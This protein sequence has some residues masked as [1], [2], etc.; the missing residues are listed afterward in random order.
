MIAAAMAMMGAPSVIAASS[1][2]G[3]VQTSN[4]DAIKLDV[5]A[6]QPTQMVRNLSGLFGNASDKP[7]IVRNQRQYRKLVRQNPNIFRSKK[8]RNNN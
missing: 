2:S 5:K 6:P 1:N 4:R 8:H 7:Y 3:S